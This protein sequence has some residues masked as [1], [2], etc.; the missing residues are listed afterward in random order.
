[1]TNSSIPEILN[2]V[3]GTDEKACN[4]L[5][6]LKLLQEAIYIK[7]GYDFRDY[8]KSHL[9][10]R[11]HNRIMLEGLTSISELQYHILYQPHI[12]QRLLKDLSI[13]VTE[14]FRDPEFYLYVRKEIVPRLKT[15]P[16]I[17]VWHAGC[18]TG[19]EVISMCILFKEEG[20]YDKTQ[21]YATD[22]NQES[23]D[24]AQQGIY[25]LSRI[26]SYTEN[27]I[28]AGGTKPFSEYYI[29][30]SESARFEKKL[31]QNVV[32]SD[33]NLVSDNVFSEMNLIICR[34]VLIY[35]NNPLKTRVMELFGNSLATGGY[36]CLG[37]K[38]NYL[39][40]RMEKYFETI[41]PHLKIFRK[42]YQHHDQ[43]ES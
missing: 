7:Y 25:N 36:L 31:I 9:R 30:N 12:F 33:H 18:A 42:I 24:K 13:N 43:P 14:M 34:N 1:M 27:Y 6:E 38:E 5:I 8:H 41:Q 37:T 16:F 4:E 28:R 2:T 40:I 39:N 10:R 19:E 21:F 32:F 17:K 15:Y 23:L 26:K 3:S 22:F 29:T 20:L 35:F 11:I